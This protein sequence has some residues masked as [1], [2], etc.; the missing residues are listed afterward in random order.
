MRFEIALFSALA[1]VGSLTACSENQTVPPDHQ[2]YGGGAGGG[3][4]CVPNLDGKI[5]AAELQTAF[6]VPAN[7]LVSPSGE[8]R[9]VDLKGK[10]GT[11]GRPVWDFG[12]DYKTD[13]VIKVVAEHV[14]GQW[15]AGSFPGATF[16]APVDAAG[17]LMGVYSGNESEIDLL[18]IASKEESPKEGKTLFVYDKPIPLY[19][20]PLAPGAAWVAAGEITNGMVL[21]LPYAGKDVYEI[22]D[23][24]AGELVLPSLTLTQVHRV[25]THIVQT[26]AAGMSRDTRQTSFLF[27]CF[28]EVTRA[29]SK[30]GEPNDDFTT[31]AELRRFGQ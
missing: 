20:F 6:G 30:D 4:S 7:Y 31:A 24:A 21:G 5:E 28:G 9:M 11:D 18:G 17:T 26:P 19:R 10:K 23:D 25:R 14:T 1:L 12:T 27:E 16:T 22:K 3:L 15:F 29:T 8:E 2:G 13:R